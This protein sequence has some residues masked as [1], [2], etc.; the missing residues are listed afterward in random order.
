MAHPVAMLFVIAQ[1]L[2][3]ST[4]FAALGATPSANAEGALK[5]AAME[6]VVSLKVRDMRGTEGTENKGYRPTL[7]QPSK[8]SASV[9]SV[10][11]SA[12]PF[13]GCRAYEYP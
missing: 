4:S 8:C 10:Q 11:I 12:R 6:S 2:P 9:R 1:P 3:K 5:S 7:R 13:F